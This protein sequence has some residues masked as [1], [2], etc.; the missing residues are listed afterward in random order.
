MMHRS[1]C[2]VVPGAATVW[3]IEAV[4]AVELSRIVLASSV[5][6]VVDLVASTRPVEAT[7]VLGM[8]PQ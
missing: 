4:E 1:A 5:G 3:V 8:D 6:I 2:L 7:E